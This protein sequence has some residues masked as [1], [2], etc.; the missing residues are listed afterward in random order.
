M[1]EIDSI[2]TKFED[3]YWSWKENGS[4]EDAREAERLSDKM[5]LRLADRFYELSSV[6]RKLREIQKWLDQLENRDEEDWSP[7]TGS[8]DE[9]LG[10]K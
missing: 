1:D 9:E 6:C 3:R 4:N 7:K 5:K 2:M 8:I 10:I